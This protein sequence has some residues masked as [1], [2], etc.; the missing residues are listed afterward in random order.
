MVKD[1][2]KHSIIAGILV[3]VSFTDSK[4][5]FPDFGT[6]L[7]SGSD[8]MSL[9][10][11]DYVQP[12]MNTY[13]TGISSGW[14]NTAAPHKSLGFDLTIYGSLVSVPSAEKTF[15]FLQNNYNS[16][17]LSS[18]DTDTQM[19]TL[20][21]GT[22][23]EQIFADY[24]DPGTGQQI[25]TEQ[26]NAPGGL[27]ESLPTSKVPVPMI[28][29]A[30]GIVKNT[31]LIVRYAPAVSL[32]DDFTFKFFGLGIK[33]DIKQWIPGLK[34]FPLD[35]SILVGY[36][37]LDTQYK[38]PTNGVVETT[39]GVG[40]FDMNSWT[41]QAL[42]S[43]KISVITFYGSLGYNSVKSNFKMLGTYTIRDA[44]NPLLSISIPDPVNIDFPISGFRTTLGM[45][46][47][48]ALFT[49]HADYTLQQYNTLTIGFGI[50][51]R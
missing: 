28:Q 23:S 10:M 17:R 43:K 34:S 3:V 16:L 50:S 26:F 18:G 32:G 48:L 1:L 19:P 49:F 22:T 29:F 24:T 5:Q 2:I 31:E 15:Q 36:T 40:F 41:F 6:L 12:F 35:L 37:N 25:V 47:K 11:H 38:F 33:H 9:Y 8:D 27:E 46:L 39:D 21:G 42:I 44:N 30:I 7:A 20:L 4:A 51:V 14:Y 45:R 13:G